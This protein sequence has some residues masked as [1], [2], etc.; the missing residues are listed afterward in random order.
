M[1]PRL[2]FVPAVSL[3][4]PYVGAVDQT[5]LQC[6]KAALCFGSELIDCA[7]IPVIQKHDAKI[8]IIAR[9]CQ[10][11]DNDATEHTL[12]SLGGKVRMVPR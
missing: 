3:I 1:C 4:S 6:R 12:P 9:A 10:P 11:V 8:L 5:G 2:K 7:V